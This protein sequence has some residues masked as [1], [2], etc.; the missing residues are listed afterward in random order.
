MKSLMCFRELRRLR[1]GFT[2]V[3]LLVAIAI[4]EAL[5]GTVSLATASDAAE[6]LDLR[7]DFKLR[8][9][10][11]E[12]DLRAPLANVMAK[13]HFLEMRTAAGETTTVRDADFTFS[14]KGASE[15][16]SLDFSKEQMDSGQP[17][18]EVWCFTP[19]YTFIVD[20]AL[21]DSDYV[22]RRHTAEQRAMTKAKVIKSVQIDAYTS[23]ASQMYD[24]PL[25][26]LLTP[27]YEIV[28]VT[29]ASSEPGG[30]Q[31]MHVTFRGLPSEGFHYE[32][33]F[34]DLNPAL[35]WSISRYQLQQ[36]FPESVLTTMGTVEC[37]EWGESTFVFPERVHIENKF[38]VKD[39]KVVVDNYEA[40]FKQVDLW[41]V[42]DDQFKLSAFGLPDIPPSGASTRAQRTLLLWSLALVAGM[43]VCLVVWRKRGRTRHE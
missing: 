30:P 35:A 1:R 31:Q 32:S 20:K 16:F 24:L 7:E 15:Q 37:K 18:T 34:V 3:E 38:D 8:C 33:G 27:A 25:A 6:S 41:G 26:E 13:G 14:I 42:T 39:G 21:S 23:A 22:I 4:I 29:M 12:S 43:V 10:S 11:I 17:T 28:D 36:K 5:M 2:I 9:K 19:D 40:L